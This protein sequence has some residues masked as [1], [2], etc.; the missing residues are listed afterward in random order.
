MYEPEVRVMDL[1]A[2]H[3]DGGTIGV[4]DDLAVPKLQC[5]VCKH[6]KQNIAPH[7]MGEPCPARMGGPPQFWEKDVKPE[8]E[9]SE[10]ALRD[11]KWP[12]FMACVARLFVDVPSIAQLLK[13]W[14]LFVA[15]FQAGVQELWGKENAA[16]AQYQAEQWKTVR[17]KLIALKDM[18]VVRR[19]EPGSQDRC[20]VCKGPNAKAYYEA[21]KGKTLLLMQG[22]K[23]VGWVSDLELIDDAVHG[24][25]TYGNMT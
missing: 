8:F 21:G 15:G 7:R 22:D 18:T 4:T 19:F 14:E 24:T 25:I 11:Q 5:Y 23:Q 16:M 13:Y 12:G 3:E 2:C 20:I 17:A 9:L 10:H 6:C 1:D